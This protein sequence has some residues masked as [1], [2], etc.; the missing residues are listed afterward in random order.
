MPR[1]PSGIHPLPDFCRVTALLEV[2]VLAEVLA[3][4]LA[5]SP[6]EVGGGFWREL[7]L[8]SLYIQ[9]IALAGVGL[10]CL[11]RRPLQRLDWR[12]A[13]AAGLA[14]MALITALV[15]ELS[16]SL[17]LSTLANFRAGHGEFILRAVLI[18]LLIS[19]VVLRYFTVQQQWRRDVEAVQ[20]A[21]LAALQSR[22]QPHFLF[23]S[24]NTIASLIPERPGQAEGLI[25]DLSGL[26]RASL[27]GER[28]LHRLADEL[29]LTRA[30]LNLEQQRLGERLRVEWQVGEI[31]ELEVP[32]LILQPL[33]E[34]AVRHGIEPLTGGGE[35]KVGLKRSSGALVLTVENPLGGAPGGSGNRMALSNVEERLQAVFGSASR[36]WKYDEGDRFRVELVLPM[37][38]ES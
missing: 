36:L 11:L 33:V 12:L 7:G 17:Y 1:A 34:N 29:E 5:L 25:E 26:F 8:Y 21:R 16:Y 4:L 3:I 2:V 28:P 6:S 22:I 24:L 32:P 19:A 23:N 20:R 35:V 37:K 9:W 18:S 27:A 30:Y 38:D 15:S 13:A 14:V 31:P 10:L